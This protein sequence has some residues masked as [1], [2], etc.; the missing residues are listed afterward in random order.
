M[1]SFIFM[2]LFMLLFVFYDFII[3]RSRVIK[4][5]FFL[6]DSLSSANGVYAKALTNSLDEL[7]YSV[8]F[9]FLRNIL[10]STAPA[11]NKCMR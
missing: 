8:N 6:C 1:I 2:M 4:W 3:E 7:D 5:I 11:F 10:Y 9:I